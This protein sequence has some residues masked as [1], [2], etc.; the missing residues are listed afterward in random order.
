MKVGALSALKGIVVS[1]GVK[2]RRVPFGLYRDLILELDLID[3]TQLFLG[4]WERETYAFVRMAAQRS[5]WVIDV[6]SGRG[7]LCL[8]FLKQSSAPTV[9]AIEPNDSERQLMW[10]NLE[11]NDCEGS[12]SL[13]WVKK[14][15]GCA[16]DPNFIRLD[17][18]PVDLARRG[19][20]KIDVDGAEME[21][22]Q[23]GTDFL[24][25]GVMD[26]LVE[27]HS[28]L[29]EQACSAFL[30]EM[31][32]RCQIIKNAWWRVIIPGNRPIAHNRWLWATKPKTSPN[33]IAQRKFP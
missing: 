18:M 30:T 24:L 20:I 15:V 28:L 7:E 5:E 22:L 29:L 21:V 32:F 12:A 13:V 26:V 25:N 14:F 3:R 1:R 31:G 11:L 9:I 2:P 33:V 8:F 6:G 17:Q 16:G 27:T 4:L 19:F 23:S 10:R